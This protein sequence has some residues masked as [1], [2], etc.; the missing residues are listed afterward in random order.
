MRQFYL[1]FGLFCLCLAFF[2]AAYGYF[3]LV[4]APGMDIGIM[5]FFEK[6]AYKIGRFIFRD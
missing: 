2:F 1:I 3:I 4:R 6:L 5:E